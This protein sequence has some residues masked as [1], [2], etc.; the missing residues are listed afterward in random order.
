MYCKFCQ[1]P[2][3]E[4]EEIAHEDMCN[5]HAL[6]FN[7]GTIVTPTPRNNVDE[8]PEDIEEFYNDFRTDNN[9]PLDF[10]E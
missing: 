5:I 2:L 1:K 8:W 7:S 10:G 9:E 6:Q 4:K 3:T